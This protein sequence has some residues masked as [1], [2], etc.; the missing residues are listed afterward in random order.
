MVQHCQT[1]SPIDICRNG[2]D[3]T[4]CIEGIIK[5]IWDGDDSHSLEVLVAIREHKFQVCFQLHEHLDALRDLHPRDNF[6]LFLR[7]AEV[8]KLKNIPKLSTVPLRLIFSDGV[9]LLRKRPDGS[10]QNLNTW[11]GSFYYT[12]FYTF[13][14][15]T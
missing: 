10:I 4:K 11:K 14:T 3:E 8:K 6:R 7:G 5:G 12:L 15:F 2:V 9:N 13:I 1:Q